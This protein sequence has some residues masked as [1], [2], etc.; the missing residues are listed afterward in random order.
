MT[1]KKDPI[2]LD[3]AV[4]VVSDSCG[5]YGTFYV[6]LT[7]SGLKT[8]NSPAQRPKVAHQGLQ[9]PETAGLSQPVLK[10]PI[11]QE[12]QPLP[13]KHALPIQ[14]RMGVLKESRE[15][16]H[17]RGG[18]L[19]C[20]GEGTHLLG[21]GQ[22]GTGSAIRKV[23]KTSMACLSELHAVNSAP[24]VPIRQQSMALQTSPNAHLQRLSHH[25]PGNLTYF[26]AVTSCFK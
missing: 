25:T 15:K 23:T 22:S 24:L 11:A 21:V 16:S 13:W 20:D 4:P 3:T 8:F 18:S 19:I 9:A 26:M 5:V 17:K 7:S 2:P 1:E 14:P 6:D 10:I 12:S